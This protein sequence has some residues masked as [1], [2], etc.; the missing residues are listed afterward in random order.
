[1]K[2]RIIVG[3]FLV[4]LLIAMLCFGGYF[5]L[6][7][8]ALVSFA[9]TYE[10]AHVITKRGFRPLVFPAYVFALAFPFVYHFGGLVILVMFYLFCIILSMV[11]SVLSGSTDASIAVGTLLLYV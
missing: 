2:T 4:A 9:A 7:T 5:Y 11:F 8:L 6:A 3:A 10:V 1:M